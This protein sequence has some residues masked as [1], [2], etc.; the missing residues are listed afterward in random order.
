MED[1][2]GK[3]KGHFEVPPKSKGGRRSRS[4]KQ[5]EAFKKN[6]RPW[7][8]GQSGNVGGTPKSVQEIQR[9]A[10]EMTPDV[11]IMFNDLAHDPKV[12]PRDRIAAG[13]AISDR[14]C[15]RPAIGV[16]HGVAETLS[17]PLMTEA[18]EPVSALIIRA[19]RENRDERALADLGAEAR[20]L[21]DKLARD[22][23]A[24]EASIAEAADALDRGEDVSG[25][26]RLLL[27]A[28][29]EKAK[30]AAAAPP[31]PETSSV[32]DEDPEPGT[33]SE[34]G[35]V[36]QFSNEVIEDPIIVDSAG[37]ASSTPTAPTGG[38]PPP[39]PPK[40]PPFQAEPDPPRPIPISG[41][42]T[43]TKPAPKAKRTPPPGA[44]YMPGHAEFLSARETQERDDDM[45]KKVE[46]ARAAGRPQIPMS[47]LPPDP[48]PPME[49]L[50][51]T[52]VPGGRG[53][54]RC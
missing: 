22:K 40:A 38:N 3:Y 28:R 27:H 31:A 37:I 23:E 14:G 41:T 19:A 51:F 12:P 48:R 9:M 53:I 50:N 35:Q 4:P 17:S 43:A 52:R 39:P 42:G 10:R 24:H 6:L 47:E 25:V 21:E 5:I 2:D 30:R 46:A 34:T 29:A 15:G 16:F 7:K 26:T 33:C 20:R 32:S 36:G 13:I 1:D 8:P 11:L 45:A 54:K 18:G 44:P 49:V